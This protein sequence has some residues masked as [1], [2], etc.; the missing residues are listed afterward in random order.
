MC[1]VFFLSL[2]PLVSFPIPFCHSRLRG[3]DTITYA[4]VA[5]WC[6]ARY[7]GNR[8]FSNMEV[9]MHPEPIQYLPAYA[10]KRLSRLQRFLIRHFHF[11][12]ILKKEE[13]EK[14]P[15]TFIYLLW[16]DQKCHMPV[17]GFVAYSME[18]PFLKCESCRRA[19]PITPFPDFLKPTFDEP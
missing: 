5:F 1:A 2:H 18:G 8:S 15:C 19:Y 4:T 13:K 16:C 7:G 6:Y 9:P 3:N 17:R 10:W 14:K 11:N 12:C